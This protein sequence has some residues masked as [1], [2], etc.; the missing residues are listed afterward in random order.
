MKKLILPIIFILGIILVLSFVSAECTDSDGGKSFYTKGET[1]VTYPGN[2]ESSQVSSGNT[3]YSFD[4][5]SQ[6]NLFESV[7]TNGDSTYVE[8]KCLNECFDG[9]CLEDN[10]KGYVLAEKTELT[11]SLGGKNYIISISNIISPSSNGINASFSLKFSGDLEEITDT[12]GVG[13]SQVLSNGLIIKVTDTDAT[14][15]YGTPASVTFTI[16][17]PVSK[18][19]Q[20]QNKEIVG[21]SNNFS[22]YWI[23]GGVIVIILI[24]LFFILRKKK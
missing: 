24:I 11:A 18:N 5:C 16:S 20:K 17:D 14:R 6:N 7:C 13:E 22:I 23:T 21:E 4:Y 10:E 9:F 12:L 19:G 8:Y 1:A 15:M 3:G 2:T